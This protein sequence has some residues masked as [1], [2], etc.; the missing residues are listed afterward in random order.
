VPSGPPTRSPSAPRSRGSLAAI[1][2]L[3]V[4]A[5]GTLALALGVTDV[6]G[7]DTDVAATDP[8]GD[9]TD[10]ASDAD[11]DPGPDDDADAQATADG[12]DPAE[13]GDASDGDDGDDG[14]DGDERGR[15]VIHHTGDVSLDHDY[16]PVFRS[17]GPAAAW[18]GVR[19]TFATA[20]LVMVNLECAATDGGTPQAKQFV[21]RCDLGSLPAMRDAGV[22]V[23]T[24]ANNHSGDYG[25][26]AMV[27]SVSNVEAAGMVAVGVGVDEEDAYRPRIVEAAGWRVAVL[28]FGGVVPEISW[29]ASGDR[30]GQPTG[31]DAERMAQAVRA[32]AADADL[33]VVTVHWGAEG[34]LTPRPEDVTKARALAA[35]GADVVF[36]HHA[37]R[38][39][40]VER[41]DGLPVFWNLGNFIWPRLSDAGARTAIA[42]WV[43]E[44]DGTT[45]ACLLPAEIDGSGV[46]RMT[47]GEPDCV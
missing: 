38:L 23:V 3:V 22:D 44:P 34:A 11:G 19:D 46:P 20:D 24:L 8:P 40:P 45:S 14:E 31:Y 7:T 5:V 41:V 28:G 36:G 17:D 47:G 33:V 35:A 13:A 15:L 37:H 9:A 39:Q 4:L 21:F 30:P 43:I 10:G 27:E 42:E 29:H 1:V 26:P 18:D 32:A 16:V 12:D 6:A 2:V 25:I